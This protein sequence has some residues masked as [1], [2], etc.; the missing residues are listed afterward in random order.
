MKKTVFSRYVAL[1][2][3]LLLCSFC[4]LLTGCGEEEKEPN[5]PQEPSTPVIGSDPAA[6]DLDWDLLS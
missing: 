5:T 4:F 6:D 2:V 1:L 3:A